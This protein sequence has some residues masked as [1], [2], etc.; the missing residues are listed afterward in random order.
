MEEKEY[1]NL[2]EDSASITIEDLIVALLDE[3]PPSTRFL[4][5][6][7]GLEAK[8]LEAVNKAWLSLSTSRKYTLLE[9]L[10][11]LAHSTT[12]VDFEPIYQLGLEDEDANVRQVAIRGLWDSENPALIRPLLLTALNQDE[13]EVAAEAAIAL[14]HF[15][16]LA[17]IAKI[18]AA[19]GEEIK[20]ALIEVF[21]QEDAPE[22]VRQAAIQSL[23][24]AADETISDLIQ[25]AYDQGGNAWIS[26]GL[27]AMGHSGEARWAKQVIDQLDSP[28]SDIRL[29]AVKAAGE[30]ELE[31]A[32]ELL[33]TYLKESDE[34]IRH[35]AIW[36]LSEIGDKGTQGALEQEQD[37]TDDPVEKELLEEAIDNI[38]FRLGL[39]DFNIL[40][41]PSP[42]EQ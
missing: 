23:G 5:R 8:E 36:S 33:L 11:D 34:N 6:M 24:Y 25:S 39:I 20:Q 27:A 28:D 16:L 29:Q 7:S 18:S 40:E 4:V 3:T 42:D 37:Q 10:D 9:N 1:R 38:S 30:L 14:G 41:A 32:E 13:V 15:L 35:A 22:E 2:L 21:L 26:A 12:L 31:G 19:R 17:V